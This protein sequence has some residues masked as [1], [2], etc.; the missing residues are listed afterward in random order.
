MP[1]FVKIYGTIL[2][3]SVWS[4]SNSTR[5]VWITML[6]LADRNGLVRSSTR[7][8]AHAARVTDDECREALR[9]L[10]APDPDSSS[11]QHEGRRIVALPGG[12]VVL[13]YTTYREMRTEDQ[14]MAADKKR[15]Q[16]SMAKT[17][18]TAT[19]KATVNAMVKGTRPGTRGSVPG[20]FTEAEAEAEA[21]G[22]GRFS[23]SNEK[24]INQGRVASE[25]ITKVADQL[26]TIVNESNRT[27]FGP[28]ANEINATAKSSR[29]MS[30]SLIRA[31]I[32]IEVAEASIRRQATASSK[33]PGSLT[34]F[35]QG[36]Q[37][38]YHE[39]FSS[40]RRSKPE[41]RSGD[42]EPISD[43][44]A[45]AAAGWQRGTGKL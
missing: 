37:Q 34:Y 35:W 5:L 44:I 43:L 13:N 20:H 10:L 29:A 12:W 38:D 42:A 45:S 3:S 25:K 7:G 1:G 28:M 33:Q 14:I 18:A 16:R 36:I 27:R 21:D 8:L 41:T 4:E 2:N 9:V 40:S 11:P 22:E 17:A 15:R 30:A 31:G 26:V 24:T 39:Q 32:P 23:S 6:A 19:V